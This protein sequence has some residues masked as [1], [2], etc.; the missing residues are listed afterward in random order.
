MVL[1]KGKWRVAAGTS[2][3]APCW[4][5]IWSLIRQ[6]TAQSGKTLGAAAPLVY[7]IGNSG[8][9]ARAFDDITSGSNGKYH[10]GIG[11]DAVTGWGT[12]NA[13]ALVTAA[14]APAS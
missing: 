5:G 2:L 14:L 13:S 3:G 8:S 7:A 4:A 10:A 9:Y 6:D 1:Y 11:W 12:P